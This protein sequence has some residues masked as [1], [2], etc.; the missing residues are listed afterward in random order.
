MVVEGFVEIITHEFSNKAGLFSHALIE[1]V[2]N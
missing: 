2:L 1:D